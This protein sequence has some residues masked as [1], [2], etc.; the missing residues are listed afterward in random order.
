MIP[1]YTCD[2][3]ENNHLGKVEKS[4]LGNKYN[5]NYTAWF[6]EFSYQKNPYICTCDNGNYNNMP[7]LNFE[8][9]G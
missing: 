5:F 2:K 6:E 8:M 1:A 9:R 4:K 7:D 3:L